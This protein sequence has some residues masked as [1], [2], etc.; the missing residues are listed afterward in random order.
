[1]APSE[2]WQYVLNDSNHSEVCQ[3]TSKDH[4]PYTEL[5]GF[6][7]DALQLQGWFPYLIV[8]FRKIVLYC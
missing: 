8:Y 7:S 3:P 1:M 2:L 6:L 5:L 4:R